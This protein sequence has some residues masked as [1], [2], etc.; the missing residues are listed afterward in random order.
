MGQPPFPNCS[1]TTGLPWYDHD[2][3]HNPLSDQTDSPQKGQLTDAVETLT[4]SAF[5]LENKE[6]AE[7]AATLLRVWFLNATTRPT[8]CNMSCTHQTHNQGQI[9]AFVLSFWT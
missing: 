8:P 5:F 2:G 6:H 9:V 4:L 7:R 1:T 3:Y